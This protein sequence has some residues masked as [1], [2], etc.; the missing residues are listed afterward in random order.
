MK[1]YKGYYEYCKG[2]DCEHFIDCEYYDCYLL[3]KNSSHNDDDDDFWR[4]LYFNSLFKL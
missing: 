2:V 4:T 3:G 1:C